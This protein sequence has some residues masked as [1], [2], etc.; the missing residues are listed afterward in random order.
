M[1][2]K[3]HRP[4]KESD[5]F[6]TAQRAMDQ[7]EKNQYEQELRSQGVTKSLK[8]GIGFLGKPLELV[9]ERVTD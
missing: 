5:L 4:R 7:I 6:E 8:I 1:E 9:S 2:L 3:T